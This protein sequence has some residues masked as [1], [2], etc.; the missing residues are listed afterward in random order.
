VEEGLKLTGKNAVP[1]APGS[2]KKDKRKNA[3]PPLPGGSKR[4]A[5]K[6]KKGKRR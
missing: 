5:G 4:R 6:S 2:K 3:P 1:S